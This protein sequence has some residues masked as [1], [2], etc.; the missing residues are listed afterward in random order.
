MEST[1]IEEWVPLREPDD[2]LDDVN[3]VLKELKV[4]KSVPRKLRA[5]EN[6]LAKELGELFRKG[7]ASAV[8]RLRDLGR[9]PSDQEIN[10]IARLVIETEEDAIRD[11]LM[12]NSRESGQYGRNRIHNL[13]RQAGVSVSGERDMSAYV[14]EA[15]E[16]RAEEGLKEFSR[17]IR[18]DMRSS[19]MRSYEDGVGTE[20]TARR[21]Q[22]TVGDIE[23]HRARTIARTEVNCAQ[24]EG[25]YRTMEEEG[26]T[27]HQWWTAEDERVRDGPDADH[28][29]MHGET[30]RI[31]ETFSNG[32]RH[33]GD[34]D[35]P[36]EEWIN[37]RCVAIP[38]V[39]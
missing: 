25:S 9:F 1:D 13:L 6:K 29:L 32:L 15:L 38:V 3:E 34:R 14:L 36:I 18:D 30:V 23:R 28:V 11:A 26:I 17:T 19:L 10:L 16:E 20:E 7:G 22:E 4:Q 8:A 12:R 33:P 31:G 37:C 5:L 35:G 39:D 2:I 27:H 21:L 24:N